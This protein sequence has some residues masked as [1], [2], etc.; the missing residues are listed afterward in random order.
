MATPSAGDA[1]VESILADLTGQHL[2]PDAREIELLELARASASRIA[3][4]EAIVVVEGTTFTDA[5]GTMRPSPLLAEIRCTTVILARLLGGIQMSAPTKSKN[6]VKQRAGQ[7]SWAARST[8]QA[9]TDRNAT[10]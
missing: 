6:P 7:A 5:A 8:R 3:E 9:L 1:L 2:R 10:A 4:L